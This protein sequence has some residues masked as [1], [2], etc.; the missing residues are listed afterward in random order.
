MK[1]GRAWI[2]SLGLLSC[3]EE[4]KDKATEEFLVK[5]FQRRQEILALKGEPGGS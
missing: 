4:R 2:D 1:S 3:L 5:V